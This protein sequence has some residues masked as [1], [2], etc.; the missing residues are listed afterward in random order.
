MRKIEFIVIRVSGFINDEI[1]FLLKSKKDRTPQILS[2]SVSNF[3]N[4]DV[5]FIQPGDLIEMN[6]SVTGKPMSFT[7]KTLLGIFGDKTAGLQDLGFN[8]N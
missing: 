4:K 3:E 7:N 2:M 8:I 5:I 1:S 6:V